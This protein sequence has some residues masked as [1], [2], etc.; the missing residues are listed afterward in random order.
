VIDDDD[1]Q[2]HADPLHPKTETATDTK[3]DKTEDALATTFT[4]K[5][6]WFYV[7]WSGL[8]HAHCCWVSRH[9]IELTRNIMALRMWEEKV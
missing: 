6:E 8:S 4:S 3:T 5:D 7:S 1:D 2:K 9:Y